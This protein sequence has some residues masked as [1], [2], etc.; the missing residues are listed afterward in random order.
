MIVI[1]QWNKFWPQE[2]AEWHK[3]TNHWKQITPEFQNSIYY[4][5]M[6]LIFQFSVSFMWVMAAI[7]MALYIKKT[8]CISLYSYVLY[9]WSSKDLYISYTYRV[10]P[11]YW[12]RREL[13]SL[14][15]TKSPPSPLEIRRSLSRYVVIS[16]DFVLS[17]GIGTLRGGRPEIVRAIPATAFSR[18]PRDC[19]RGDKLMF[20][21]KIS[22]FSGRSIF[23]L[24]SGGLNVPSL[25]SIWKGK[26]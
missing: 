25:N 1:L 9:I 16:Q 22:M 18:G 23:D 20:W 19:C 4:M 7:Q 8:W 3:F 26:Y 5:Q 13:S 14:T 15:R 11:C 6:L 24:I 21:P 10:G 12:S 2:K 17:P